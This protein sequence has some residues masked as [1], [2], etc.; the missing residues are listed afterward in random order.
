MADLPVFDFGGDDSLIGGILLALAVAVVIGVVIV[1]LL[2]VFLLIVEVIF[3]VV[4]TTVALRPWVVRATT[5]GPPAD[6]RTWGVRGFLRSR[7]AMAE[8][9]DELRRGCRRAGRV[10]GRP[11]TAPYRIET[12][13]LVLRCYDPEDAPLLKDAST[14]ASSTCGRGCRGRSSSRRRSTRSTSGCAGS[15]AAST[16]ATTTS[17]GSSRPTSRGSLGGTGLHTRL[18]DGALEIG[19]WI[20]AD[21]VGQGFATELTAV[22]TRVGFEHFGLDRIDIRVD[23]EN[24]RSEK[25]PRKLGF[26]HEATLRRRLPTKRGSDLRDVNVC[27]MLAAELAASPCLQYEYVAYDALGRQL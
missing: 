2:P 11:L 8:V 26:T 7:R 22:L 4:A 17:W 24:E 12:E 25:V 18:G 14:G 16:S 20:A 1:V 21:A 27:T 13:R 19:Y 9:A 10:G 23:P 6:E 3:A 15:A 5:V